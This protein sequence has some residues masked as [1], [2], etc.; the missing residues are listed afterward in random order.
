MRRTSQRCTPAPALGLRSAR[1]CA[2]R[3]R[4][5]LQG[6]AGDHEDDERRDEHRQIAVAGVAQQAGEDDREP[7]GQEFVAIIAAPSSA[8]RPV[9]SSSGRPEA[10]A[11]R[12]GTGTDRAGWSPRQTSGDQR[13]TA[14]R[15]MARWTTARAAPGATPRPSTPATTTTSGDVPFET[16]T[17]STSAWS[18]RA[19]RGCLGS[20]S[21]ASA[22]NFRAAFAGFEIEAVARFG[23]RDVARLLG[24]AGMRHG[25]DRGGDRK[26]PGRRGAGRPARR[27]GRS[28]PRAGA[29]RPARAH[30]EST[31]LSKELK[32]R[33][34]ASWAP[35]PPTPRCRRAAW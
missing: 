15:V 21:C 3:A 16:T 27:A 33:G 35:P 11:H 5:H 13:R 8:A 1:S 6:R 26:R 23:E 10:R 4:R 12:R 22:K 9:S 31:A 19:S 18:S 28:R 14:A 25:E 20:P 29:R 32:R 17:A 7:Q 24:D 2:D 30:A 34:F